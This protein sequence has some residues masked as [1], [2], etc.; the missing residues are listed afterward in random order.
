MLLVLFAAL[1][2]QA[3]GATIA[4]PTSSPYY[5]GAEQLLA[6]CTAAPNTNGPELCDAYI[7]GVVDTIV[8][9]HDLIQGY[10]ICWPKPTAN[11]ATLHSVVVAYLQ[12]H[13]EFAKGI[14]ASVIDTALFDA[15]ACP[16]ALPP[17]G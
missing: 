6:M 8:S 5:V 16:G 7:A 13:P 2:A 10:H 9:N 3:G 12:A 1:P 17:G 15:Y 4:G 11:V 14:G